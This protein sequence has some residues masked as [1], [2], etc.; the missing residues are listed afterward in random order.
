VVYRDGIFAHLA[1][2]QAVVAEAE[3]LGGTIMAKAG[4]SHRL[5]PAWRK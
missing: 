4:I 5:S 3:K 2:P 1:D